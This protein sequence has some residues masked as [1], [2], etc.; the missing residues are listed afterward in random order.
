MPTALSTKARSAKPAKSDVRKRGSLIE[1]STTSG[2]AHLAMD[3]APFL[4][5]G[6]LR[7][8]VLTDA[9]IAEL[10]LK[11]AKAFEP[12]RRELTRV[13][14]REHRAAG[15]GLVRAILVT[16]CVARRAMSSKLWSSALS[17][18]HSWS[19]RMP[20]LSMSRAPPGIRK[21]S[22]RVV[23]CR[24]RSSLRRTSRVACTFSSRRRLMSVDFPTPE[25]PTSTAV[26]RGR[27][28]DLT[29]SRP[30]PSSSSRQL[31]TNT[32]A[33]NAISSISAFRASTASARSVLL[34]STA[35]TAPLSRRWS[36]SARAFPG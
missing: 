36:S 26:S 23:V 34:S 15:L 11:P 16:A 1:L 29:S 18:A 8:C 7:G 32:W 35:G 4:L 5:L 3:R 14:R 2:P 13:R 20:G 27:S 6:V 9:K 19:S 25:E 24:P 17:S 31:D 21:S 10:V 28:N 22:R 12:L 33:P 30:S